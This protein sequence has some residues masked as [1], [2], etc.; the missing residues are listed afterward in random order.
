MSE[1]KNKPA[2]PTLK[3]CLSGLDLKDE[4][5]SMRDYFAAKAMQSQIL[6]NMNLRMEDVAKWSYQYADAMLAEREKGGD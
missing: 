6:G 3:R 5:L 2:F 4:G 1:I